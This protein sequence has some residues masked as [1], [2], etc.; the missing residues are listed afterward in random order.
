MS[1]APLPSEGEPAPTPPSAE[2]AAPAKPAPPPFRISTFLLVFLFVLGLYMLVDSATRNGVATLFG[3]ALAP[4]IGFGGHYLLLTMFLAAVIEMLATALAYNWA[5]DWVKA[6]KVQKWNTAFRK[7]QQEALRSGKKDRIEALKPHQQRLTLLSSQVSM[8]QLKGMAVTWF[9]VIAIYTWV[10]L[11]I[12]H[13]NAAVLPGPCGVAYGGANNTG[14]C[15]TIGGATAN[16]LAPT[17]GIGFL[18][19]WF[20]V[21]SLYT[22]P[23]SIALRRIL[24]H[25]WLRR[26]AAAHPPP[27]VEAGAIGGGA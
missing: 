13:T 27:G 1:G 2:T 12:L 18:P 15:V 11:F 20:V 5:T 4:A 25:F 26:Y 7:A 9:L 6:A 14:A 17:P 21:F 3:A 22:I 19:L 8:A 16:L 23:T 10:G 24:K